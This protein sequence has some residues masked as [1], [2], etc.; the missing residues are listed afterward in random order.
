MDGC[1]F[2]GGDLT[3]VEEVLMDL[4]TGS[5]VSDFVHS[6]IMEFGY[7]LSEKIIEKWLS[8]GLEHFIDR[9]IWPIR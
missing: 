6:E 5:L 2:F 3:H 4:E 7:L 8:L 9:K 1:L